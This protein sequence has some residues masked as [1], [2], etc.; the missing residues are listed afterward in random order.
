M[1]WPVLLPPQFS[2]YCLDDVHKGFYR[3]MF[4]ANTFNDCFPVNFL[5]VLNGSG[6]TKKR[7]QAVFTAYHG[8]DNDPK[9]EF[10]DVFVEIKHRRRFVVGGRFD[11]WWCRRYSQG[12][13]VTHCQY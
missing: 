11:Q 6:E 5:N 12:L 9:Q 13:P 7:F 2:L 4:A 10:E 3:L 1:L 8:L